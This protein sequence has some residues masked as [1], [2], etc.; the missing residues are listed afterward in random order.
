[1]CGI[2]GFQGR[3]REGLL[4]AMSECI[5]HR[6]PD[7]HGA[8]IL[9][10]GPHETVSALAHR[11]LS[12]ID[13]SAAG[14]QPMHL[15][16]N[17]CGARGPNDLTLIFNGEI[18]NYRE[19]R[20][21]LILRGHRFQSETDSEVLLHL[22]SDFGH[23]MLN[24]LN[25]I[26]A[27]AIY[28]GREAGRPDGVARHDLF[29]ARD[30][31]GVK[32]LYYARLDD[33]VLFASELKALLRSSEVSRELD[34]IALQQYVTFLWAPGEGTPLRSVRKLE[35]GHAMV[36]RAGAMAHKWAY[37]D[38]PYGNRISSATPQQIY[39]ELRSRV[40]EAVSRQ[41]VADVPVGAFLSGGLDSSAVVAMMQRAHP[42]SPTKC[43]C[44]GFADDAD[45]DNASDVPYARRVAAHLGA[46]L[47]VLTAESSIIDRLDEM[48]FLL[49]EP[50]ADPA[51]LNA[52]MIAERARA[53]GVTVLMSGAGGDDLFSGYRRHA[54][55]HYER[56]WSWLPRV[57]RA[58]L[59]R[60]ARAMSSGSSAI[61]LGNPLVRRLAKTMSFADLPDDE[62][63]VSY[64]W[65]NTSELRDTLFGPVL[66]EAA[67]T[68]SASATMLR[69]LARIPHERDPLNRMLY[70]EGKHFLADHNLNYTD[71]AGMAAG[72]EV[73]VPLLDLELVE[74]A[75]R[76][77]PNLKQD[78]RL[79]KA[80][81][82][83][84]MEPLLPHDVIYRAKSGFGAPL[85][86]WLRVELRDRVEDTLSAHSLRNRGLFEPVA[87]RR[88]I[89]LDRAGR[90]DG[91]YTI[92]ALMC[93]EVWCR[94]FIDHGQPTRSA[95][96]SRP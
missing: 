36:L 60:T 67:Q 37:W 2:A 77:P 11:R 21:E 96:V 94:L 74:F 8:V 32:P 88:L 79:G 15:S 59:A 81:F 24:R 41:L 66:R 26:F 27:L 20:R 49:D 5:A 58:P 25:G 28:D 29:V 22:Y 23:G 13:L 43:Y 75:S 6:G 10:G 1:M 17:H 82:K 63:L 78:G 83:R 34:P 39:D 12:I 84:A 95:C 53:D 73:R 14:A 80:V 72:V 50:Q 86:R 65:W 70:L 9:E 30:Q 71:K 85:R 33:A 46:D 57:L 69:S 87:V 89:D 45:G 16:C 90:I 62:R 31:M 35:P 55:L 38:M 76:I 4:E 61:A 48:L 44:I 42:G 52:L 64:F 3:L 7:G 56:T 47:T 93:I 68:E 54:A 92:F 91:S 19:L 18:Y 51:P 40:E